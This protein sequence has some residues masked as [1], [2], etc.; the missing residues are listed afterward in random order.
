MGFCKFLHCSSKGQ[1]TR[2][3]YFKAIAEK[4]YL[5]TCIAG[6]ITMANGIDN[7]FLYGFDGE[8]C[9]SGNR[10]GGF[11]PCTNPSVN[12]AHNETGS[13]VDK[14]ENVSFVYLIGWYRLLYVISIKL[15]TFHLGCDKELLWL[16]SEK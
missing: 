6:I 11:C 4:H 9:T 1:L 7:G 12:S 5:N 16:L 8:F 14:L 2:I 10:C 3:P 13:L 15:H